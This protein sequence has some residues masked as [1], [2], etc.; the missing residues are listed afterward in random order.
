L[1]YN[2]YKKLFTMMSFNHGN[3]QKAL[4]IELLFDD[5]EKL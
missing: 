4:K 3:D 2:D 5:K 1:Q